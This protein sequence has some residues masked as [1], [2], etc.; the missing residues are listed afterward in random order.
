[1]TLEEKTDTYRNSRYARR[2]F[3]DLVTIGAG[4]IGA[5]MIVGGVVNY[6]RRRSK[7]S[8]SSDFSSSKD[9]GKYDSKHHGCPECGSTH[10]HKDWC[11]DHRGPHCG[12]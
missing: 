3:I 8:D 7:D 10:G 11:S 12:G 4:I 9:S 1:M 5:G 2:G 6:L